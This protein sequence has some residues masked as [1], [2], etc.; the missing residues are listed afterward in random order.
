MCFI[1]KKQKNFDLLPLGSLFLLGLNSALSLSLP[2]L[3]STLGREEKRGGGN[4]SRL[5]GNRLVGSRP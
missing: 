2:L 5:P 1:K 4:V 3:R